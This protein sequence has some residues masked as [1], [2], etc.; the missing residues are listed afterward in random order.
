M[1]ATRKRTKL[2]LGTVLLLINLPVL[3]AFTDAASCFVAYRD[4][5]SIVSSGHPRTYVLHVP[6]SYDAA[7]PTPLI[8]SMHGAALWGAAQRDIS[9][10]DRVA[11]R[12][13]LIVVYPSGS[14]RSVP[15]VWHV[16]HG[17]GLAVDVRFISELIDTLSAHYNIDPNRIYANGL[18]NG[19]GMSF[20]LSCTLSHRIAAVGMVGAAQTLPWSWCTDRKPVPMIDFHGTADPAAPYKPGPTWVSSR[21]FPGVETWAANWARRNGCAPTP[22]DSLLRAGVRRRTYTRCANDAAVV[23]YTLYAVGHV[24]PGGAP[25]PEWFAGPNTAIVDASSEMWA[26]FK[27]HP[28]V[29]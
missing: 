12:E 28:L 23:L 3:L 25:L 10:W 4:D 17:S 24:W 1:S 14:D 29:R 6:K 27:Q 18:S 21:P 19:G 15:R 2:V 11:D 5:R 22:T 26:F 13:G 7:K 16:D 9:Q 20:V 8:I